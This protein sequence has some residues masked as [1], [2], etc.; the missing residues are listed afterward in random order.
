[1]T[2]AVERNVKQTK[3]KSKSKINPKGRGEDIVK[4][5]ICLSAHAYNSKASHRIGLT[6]L[7]KVESNSGSVLLKEDRDLYHKSKLCFV[8]FSALHVSEGF[9]VSR[10]CLI[11]IKIGA[12]KSGRSKYSRN[13][14]Y[15]TLY[16]LNFQ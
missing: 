12:N 15:P 16:Y 11:I 6:I 8:S 1:M 7:H 2:L 5:S 9:Y 13:S 14:K 3:N 10:H 4:Q